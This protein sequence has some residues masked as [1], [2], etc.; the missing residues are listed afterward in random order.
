MTDDTTTKKVW[1]PG[2]PLGSSNLKSPE[3]ATSESH[4]RVLN[5]N[6]V[7]KAIK[8]TQKEKNELIAKKYGIKKIEK[9]FKGKSESEKLR[10]TYI[11]LVRRVAIESHRDLITELDW[12][13][14]A[15]VNK[16][17]KQMSN[18]KDMLQVTRMMNELIT[19]LEKTTDVN[20]AVILS[21]EERTETDNVI[22]LAMLKL[23]R[24]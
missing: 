18:L 21:D 13:D 17:R 1:S 3:D 19:N 8:Q 20:G 4:K 6:Q 12:D 9:D 22:Q 10:M 11:E 23:N 5:Q 15:T 2:R 14:E 7:V 16:R 24:K